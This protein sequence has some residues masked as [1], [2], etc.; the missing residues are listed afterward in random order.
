M[1][2]TIRLFT[3]ITTSAIAAITLTLFACSQPAPVE[4]TREVPV[5]VEVTREL[6]VEV[7][8]EIFRETIREIPYTVEVEKEVEV[9]REVPVTVEVDLTI[10]VTREVPV[11]VEVD[12]TVEVTRETPVYVERLVDSSFDYSYRQLSYAWDA[13]DTNRDGAIGE[14]EICAGFDTDLHHLANIWFFIIRD[15]WAFSD[16]PESRNAD[17]N[18]KDLTNAE[19]CDIG[20]HVRP[21]TSITAQ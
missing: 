15:I 16:D 10:E 5:T 8:R 18:T 1:H 14:D 2:T 13:L 19:I 7:E 17:F 20:T 3:I 12:R 9:T 6:T 21:G 11:T 4:V